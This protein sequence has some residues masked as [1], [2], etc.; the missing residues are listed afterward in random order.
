MRWKCKPKPAIGEYRI[1][2]VFL[3]IPH[4]LGTE[5]RWLEWALIRALRVDYGP[6]E[7]LW[8]EWADGPEDK[9]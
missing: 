3:F 5:R 6:G 4:R 9:P 7:W 1:L 8:I 2:R